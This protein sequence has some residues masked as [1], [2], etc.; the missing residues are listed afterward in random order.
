MLLTIQACGV[1]HSI[2]TVSCCS[3]SFAAISG[4]DAVTGL[5]SPN[6]DIISNLV[7]NK[8]TA[9]PHLDSIQV[10]SNTKNDDDDDNDVSYSRR[11]LISLILSIIAIIVSSTSLILVIVN[12]KYFKHDN[13]LINSNNSNSNSDSEIID[14]LPTY[15]NINS[16]S[17]QYS[18]LNTA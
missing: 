7:I 15:N 18:Q 4:W 2:D 10:Q 17:N 14:D 16:G 11:N 5:G 8:A 13:H 6:F 1:G 3:Y 12:Y 9:F